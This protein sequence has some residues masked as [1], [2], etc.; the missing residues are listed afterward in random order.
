MSVE[1]FKD[2]ILYAT[3]HSVANKLHIDCNMSVEQF[4]RK[5]TKYST[6]ERKYNFSFSLT[7][8]PK[9]FYAYIFM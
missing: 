1:Y 9:F 2:R 4:L 6:V 5:K 8:V 3:F 7:K